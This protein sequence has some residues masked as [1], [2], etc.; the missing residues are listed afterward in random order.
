MTDK[1][2]I[3]LNINNLHKTFNKSLENEKVAL[4]DISCIFKSGTY[5]LLVG[6]NGSGKSTLLNII[7][8]RVEQDKGVVT[9]NGIDVSQLKVYERS[10]YIYRIF[11]NTL[12]GL[13]Q[14]AS[15]RENLALSLRRNKKFRLGEN[16]LQNKDL[17]MFKDCMSR[18][19]TLLTENLDKK[20]FELSPGERQAVILTLLDLQKDE[21]P[22]ILLADEPTSALDPQMAKKTIELIKKL[23]SKGWI[24][25]V[26][27]H[28]SNII[29]NSFPDNVINFNKGK[30]YDD[31]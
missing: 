9:I 2:E 22:K 29:K 17:K 11:Q 23:A 4:E 28:D 27:T 14:M 31:K 7:D 8:G 15:I 30:I 1:D 20:V 5:A 3:T 10:K 18:Y 26:V 12:N 21:S 6:H 19:N 16:L 13:V 25:L 24:C